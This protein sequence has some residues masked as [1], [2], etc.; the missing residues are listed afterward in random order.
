MVLWG[1][2]L[3]SII[4]R[5]VDFTQRVPGVLQH[6]IADLVRAAADQTQDRWPVVRVGALAFTLIGTASGRV[7]RVAM[8]HT[9]FPPRSDTAHPLRTQFRSSP[10]QGGCRR[11]W[12][13]SV[14]GVRRGACARSPVHA[15]SGRSIRLWR[16]HAAAARSSK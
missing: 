11:D 12:F 14:G 2:T 8:G 9:F 3:P 4:V 15:L 7:S 1:G 5:V 13:G 10:R 6:P 16:S